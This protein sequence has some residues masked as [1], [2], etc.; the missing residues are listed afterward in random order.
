MPREDYAISAEQ[1]RR[2][3]DPSQFDFSSTAELAPSDEVIGQDRAV[4]AISFGID[5]ESPGYHMYALGPTGT[6]KTTLVRKF[7]SRK[8]QEQPV[9][10]DWCYVNN[11][12]DSDLP[13][14]VRLPA[15]KGQQLRADMDRFV[16]EL[17]VEIP[18]ALES[19][20]Y[21]QEHERID[22]EFARRRQELLRELQEEAE[23]RRF[24]LL[25]TPQGLGFAPVLDG[26]VMTPDQFAALDEDTRQRIEE[27]QREL[28]EALHERLR[29]IPQ[30]QKEAR[31][32]LQELD[33]RTVGF[34]VSHLV[35]ELKEKYREFEDVIR[36]LDEAQADIQENAEA[37]RQMEQ[38]EEARQQIPF[39][40]LLDVQENR[41]DRYRANLLVDNSGLTGAPVILESNPN[42]YNLVGRVEHQ[43]QFGALITNF[44]MIRAGALH[45]ANG[46]YLILNAR[47]VLSKP[48]AWDALKRALQDKEIV[49]ETMGEEMRVVSTRT[50]QPEPIP[51]DV[52]VILIGDPILYYMLYAL[53]EDFQE[54]FKVKADF[55]TEMDWG[56]ECP[57]QYA[58]FIGTVCHEEGLRHFAPSGVARVVEQAARVVSDQNKLAVRFGDVVDLVRQANYWA[59]QNGNELI[60]AADVQRAID[61]MIYR[62]NRIEERLRELI[63]DDVIMIDTEG[64]VVG[65]VNGISVVPMGDY[66]FG[67][68]SRITARTAMGRAGVVNIDRE[69]GLGGRIHNKG[70]MILAGYLQGKYA[71]EVPLTLSASITFEQMY[72]EVEGDS[73]SSAELYS[74]LSSLSGFPITQELAVTGSVNQLGQVQA[75]GGVNEKIEGFYDV[76]RAKGLTGSQGVLVPRSNVQ[77]LMLRQDLV[78]AVEEGRFHIYA[79]STVDEG[80]EILTGKPAG[81]RDA[82]GRYPEGTVNYAVQERLR[83]LAEREREFRRTEGEEAENEDPQKS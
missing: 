71:E 68:P 60:E 55:A 1:L 13:R 46:G 5:I 45:R 16:D 78:K 61:E 70:V 15:G 66:A 83:Q 3:C 22:L 56:P 32:R 6:G 19:E 82:E 65:Q 27:A 50:L 10:D 62:S 64:S 35:D 20:Q 25:Q 49:I 77:N 59:G 63:E 81:E 4:R 38:L 9:P 73:A 7:L 57:T 54:L 23:A 11:F 37:F 43:V 69:I 52:K 26:E 80:I 72:E 28:Q 75:I 76:C 8:A 36:F 48:F 47:D 34:A 12:D 29:R 31:E 51:L 58:R 79:V 41:F 17:R 18:R 30:L 40:R 53:D 14:A 39:G 67:R 74:L 2:V 24:R 21:Q 44:T 42:Y 33:R